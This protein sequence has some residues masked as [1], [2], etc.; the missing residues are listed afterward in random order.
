MIGNMAKEDEN[1]VFPIKKRH[2]ESQ[3]LFLHCQHCLQ[4]AF[5]Y[6]ADTKPLLLLSPTLVSN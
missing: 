1:E 5:G 2:K 4:F 6:V 3:M